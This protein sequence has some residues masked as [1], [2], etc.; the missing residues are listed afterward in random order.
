MATYIITFLGIFPKETEYEFEGKK[1]TAQ[2]FPA[3]LRSFVEFDRMFVCVTVAANQK[4]FPILAALNDDRIEAVEIEDGE[5]TEQMW[6]NFNTI[7]SK[8]QPQDKVIFDITHAAR[9]IPFLTFL[10]SA[11]L[12]V[13]KDVEII[14]VYYGAPVFGDVHKPAPVIKLGGFISMLDWM[15]ATQRFIDLGDGNGLVKLLRGVNITDYNLKSTVD[16]TANAI[17]QVSDALIYI[18]PIEVMS[19]AA[20]LKKLIPKLKIEGSESSELQPFLLLCEQIQSKYDKLALNRPEDSRNLADNLERQLKI[21]DWYQDYQQQAKAI[22]LSRE[23]FISIMKYWLREGHEI[24][25]G[26]DARKNAEKILNRANSDPEFY[27]S[28]DRK[29]IVDRWRRTSDLRNN[30]AHLGMNKNCQSI[31]HI[32]LDINAKID[33]IKTCLRDFLR[34]AKSRNI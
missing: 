2:V 1:C 5:N 11:Y 26:Y 4:T 17:E 7:V 21:I 28:I 20:K 8:F 34:S 19:A 25:D 15:S 16:R 31:E 30:L 12:K 33:D 22:M 29:K 13:A 3:A 27:S 23:L 14:D 6:R 32:K 9:S 10:F 24:F 18:L